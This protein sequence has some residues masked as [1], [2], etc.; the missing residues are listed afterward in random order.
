MAV[1]SIESALISHEPVFPS[2]STL[3]AA[4]WPVSFPHRDPRRVV[5]F[6]VYSALYLLL[7]QSGNFQVLY[8]YNQKLVSSR[9]YTHL[10][11]THFIIFMPL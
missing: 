2:L 11:F 5:D 8:M 7:G 6:S 10:A 9:H 1:S 4:V 3:G